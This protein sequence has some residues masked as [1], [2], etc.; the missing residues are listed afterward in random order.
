MKSRTGHG[1]LIQSGQVLQYGDSR[2]EQQGMSRPRVILRIVDGRAV[3]ADQSSSRINEKLRCRTGQKGCASAVLCTGL[4]PVGVQQ[5]GMPGNL[6]GPEQFGS[7]RTAGDAAEAYD[8]GRQ[9]GKQFSRISARQL[10]GRTAAG[11]LVWLG[12]DLHVAEP[13]VRDHEQAEVPDE[14]VRE[15]VLGDV[16]ARRIES[17]PLG[18]KAPTV[19][20]GQFRVELDAILLLG[21]RRTPPI[22]KF[23]HDAAMVQPLD[24]PRL[25]AGDNLVLRPW[26]LDDLPLVQEASADE[27]IPLITTIPAE[28]SPEA[29]NAFVQRQWDRA[30]TGAGYPFVITHDNRPIGA[31]GLWLRDADQGRASL[32]YW[33]VQAARGQGVAAAALRAVTAWGLDDLRMPR[34][35]LYVEPWNTASSRTAESVGFQP[36]GLLR[37][38]QPVGQERRDMIMYSLLNAGLADRR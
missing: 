14:Q 5:D 28:Y 4:M 6:E 34:L 35:Q 31:I 37:S 25:A 27:Y 26:Q 29:G 15:F 11:S 22:A 2:R 1:N 10:V 17:E 33:V 12:D 13:D 36:E 24:V 30:A 20:E 38:W 3:D 16:R 8:D 19:R 18:L 21:H 32:G 9:V 23:Q 7:D